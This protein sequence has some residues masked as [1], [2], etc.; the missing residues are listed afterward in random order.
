MHRAREA[1]GGNVGVVEGEV[2]ERRNEEEED[3]CRDYEQGG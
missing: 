3:G 1:E 2:S